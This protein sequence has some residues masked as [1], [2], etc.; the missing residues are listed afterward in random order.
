MRDADDLCD[1]PTGW[2][3]FLCDSRALG[4]HLALREPGDRWRALGVLGATGFLYGEREHIRHF[5]LAHRTPART[6]VYN[7]ARILGKGIA[8]PIAASLLYLDGKL[9]SNSY[10]VE[11]A[12][13]LVES[14]LYGSLLAG[15]GQV[16]IASERPEDGN[17]VHFFRG[18]GHGAS[19][20]VAL[21]ASVVAPLDRRYLRLAPGDRTGR[22]V[23]KIMGRAGLY[24]ALA[25]TAAQRM[26]A[27]R[28]WAPDVLLG[29]AAGLT[30]G[31]STCS[32]HD[33]SRTTDGARSKRA[34][35]VPIP[36]GLSAAWSF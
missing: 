7:K 20:D 21:A 35:I 10:H 11:S 24:A 19:G 14:T 12:Q 30:A 13:I 6:R 8:M 5:V 25:L 17:A 9:T 1:R 2:K 16:V 3:R 29:A 15:L 32:A 4:R 18:G 33:P 36:G 28:H 23:F 31:Y 34:H 26:D 27:D 22:R